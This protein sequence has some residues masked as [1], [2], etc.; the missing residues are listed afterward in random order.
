MMYL[1][2]RIIPHP[3]H[4]TINE[5]DTTKSEDSKEEMEGEP[6]KKKQKINQ[7]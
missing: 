2:F 3:S 7:N 1:G 6:I 5:E 4:T